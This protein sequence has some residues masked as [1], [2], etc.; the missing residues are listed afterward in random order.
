M[1]SRGVWTCPVCDTRIHGSRQIAMHER[2]LKNGLCRPRAPGQEPAAIIGIPEAPEAIFEMPEPNTASMLSRRSQMFACSQRLV[3]QLPVK[4]NGNR[5]TRDMVALQVEWQHYLRQVGEQFAPKFWVFFLSMHEQATVAIDAALSGVKKAFV[6]DANLKMF[7]SSKRQLLT[8]IQKHVPPFFNRVVHCVTI[9]LSPCGVQEKLKFRFLDPLWA[10]IVAANN[11][12]PEDL[13]FV[14]QEQFDFKGDRMY[15]G[16]VQYGECFAE[17]F[18]TCP[19]GTFPMLLNLHW[20]GTAAHGLPAT[21]IAIGVANCNGQSADSHTCVGY[22]PTTSAAL[23]TT[24]KTEVKFYIRQKCVGAI[25]SLLETAARTG[26]SCRIG[27]KKVITL[28][29]RLIAMTLDQPE[30]QLYFG[31]LNGQSCWHC[32]RRKG[33]SA[34]RKSS[35][36]Q[37]SVINTLYNI[38][39]DVSLDDAMVTLAK[40]KLARYGFNAQRRC[41]LTKICNHLLIRLPDRDDVFPSVAF[42][43]VMHAA[44][45]FFHRQ[46]FEMFDN[47]TFEP[48]AETRR[49][50]NERLRQIS[51][52]GSMRDEKT[53]RSYRTQTKLFSEAHMSAADRLCTLFLIPHVLGHEGK[54]LPEQLRSPV[55][56]SIATVQQIIIALTGQRP[57]TT[58]E[59]QEIFDR[60]YVSCF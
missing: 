53:D 59:L 45:I 24:D 32:K 47:I 15:G 6:A 37:G 21:P 33:R 5:V 31:Q 35:V 30:S 40:Q 29:P 9:D 46:L 38:A 27:D 25:L 28:F 48:Q 4:V 56:R 19:T 12:P 11:L 2:A 26:V 14:P 44:V 8:R 42:R 7:A 18:R 20:D 1:A 52:D 54:V 3:G 41:L 51:S 34:Q 49:V 23:S 55:L 13:H 36:Q 57:Y 17:A 60:G 10:W 50:I 58:H 16:G 39:E 22:M 43:D